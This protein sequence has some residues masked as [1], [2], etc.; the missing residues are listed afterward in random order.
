MLPLCQRLFGRLVHVSEKTLPEVEVARRKVGG[1]QAPF[2]TAHGR[3][4]ERQLRI[5]TTSWRA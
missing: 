3:C 5:D 4:L 2:V 1:T